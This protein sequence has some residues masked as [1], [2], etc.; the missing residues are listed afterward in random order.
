MS[1]DTTIIFRYLATLLTEAMSRHRGLC[2]RCPRLQS[3]GSC[4]CADRFEQ[5]F[6]L[7]RHEIHALKSKFE[8]F[9]I[10]DYAYHPLVV[11]MQSIRLKNFE[12]SSTLEAVESEL[13]RVKNDIATLIILY[14]TFI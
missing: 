3:Y 5:E 11:V 14:P 6:A 9:A 13:K 4:T 2:S 8:N 12:R 10:G 7:L 1:H